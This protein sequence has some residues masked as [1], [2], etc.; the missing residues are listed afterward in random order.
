MR[1][2][3]S[4]R[5]A[6]AQAPCPMPTIQ[7]EAHRADACSP[8]T[9]RCGSIRRTRRSPAASSKIRT[10]FAD[11]FA[12]AWFKLT[13]RDMG[14]RVRYLGPEV[15]AEELIWQ[16]PI[17]AVNHPL[18]DAADIAALKAKILGI[19]SV[20]FANWSP[21]PGPRPPPS[22]VP[23][24]A[25]VPTVRASVS[26]RRRTGKSTN[27]PNSPRCS[28]RWKASRAS[29]TAASGG[30]KISLA[31]LIVL[32]GCAGVEQAAK[33]AGSHVTVPFTP[34]RMDASQEQTDVESFAVLEPVADGFRNYQKTQLHRL[35][36]GTA[37]RQG[38][39]A[40]PHRA[41]NDG[42]RRRPA[43]AERQRRQV[44]ARCVHQAAR[45]ADQRLLR[46]PA[47]HGHGRGSRRHEASRRLRRPRP[48]RRAN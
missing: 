13:H 44:E 34:G 19:G 46:Q 28:R 1:S 21:P 11:A 15:P 20:R 4:R 8:R 37:D 6:P 22:A 45:S 14:P 35:G 29:S 7:V 3:G 27:R 31:D 26:R 40:H 24:N 38:A 9:S 32:G 10:Q 42:A 33:N 39:V 18:I 48:R 47:R 16:D 25:A 43:R 36:G 30:K 12:R 5:T 2:S 41:G 23:T 17:P